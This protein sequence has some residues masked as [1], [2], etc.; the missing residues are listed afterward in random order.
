MSE[1]KPICSTCND[2]HNVPASDGVGP[3]GDGTRMCRSC[4]T[5]CERCRQHLGAYCRETPCSCPCHSHSFAYKDRLASVRVDPERVEME[6]I[7][8]R[9]GVPAE[10]ILLALE[11]VF[12]EASLGQAEHPGGAVLENS[13]RLLR[14][15]A[16]HLL[17]DAVSE[18]QRWTERIK[19]VERR[20][21]FAM[22]A[23]R[24]G[25]DDRLG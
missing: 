18:G 1:A 17:R 22:E 21:E 15:V 20:T 3:F 5:P 19:L 13:A 7:L 23:L 9:A 14:L 16:S 4:P 24:G 6:R 10:R 12:E 8:R 2:T 25:H 11:L